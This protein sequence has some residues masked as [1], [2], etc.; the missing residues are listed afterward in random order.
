MENPERPFCAIIGGSK[1]STKITIIEKLMEKV[2]S[3]IIGG[4]MTYTFAGAEGGKEGKS[5]CEPDMFPVA[6]EI[7]KKAE[8]RGIQILRSPDALICDDFSENANTQRS[9]HR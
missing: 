2:D 7:L 3:I 1:V 8:E 4:G 6:L 9:R 5:I